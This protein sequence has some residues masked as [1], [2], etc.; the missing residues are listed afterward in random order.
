MRGRG[1]RRSYREPMSLSRRC[2]VRRGRE[3]AGHRIDRGVTATP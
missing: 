2:G 3:L 1:S